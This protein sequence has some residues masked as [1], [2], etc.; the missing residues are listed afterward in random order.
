MSATIHAGFDVYLLS[1][2]GDSTLM[3]SHTGTC[4]PLMTADTVGAPPLISAVA[5]TDTPSK[6]AVG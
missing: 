1:K 6:G 3:P 4:R 5:R 2:V